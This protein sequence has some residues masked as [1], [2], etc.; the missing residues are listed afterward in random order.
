MVQLTFVCQQWPLR[1]LPPVRAAQASR[2][3]AP[4]MGESRARVLAAGRPL[5]SAA[6]RT[7]EVRENLTLEQILDMIAAIA[8]FMAR[9]PTWSQSCTPR[10][11]DFAP[12]RGEPAMPVC[13]AER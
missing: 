11:M 8:R 1:K 10:S 6:Q 9:P 3:S 13:R 7:H 12:R 5:L 2:G 4:V